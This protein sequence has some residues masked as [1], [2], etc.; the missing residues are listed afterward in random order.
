MKLY[1]AGS[2]RGGR[3]EAA[4]Y[5]KIIAELRRYG[6]V[7]T[8]HIGDRN[9]TDRGENTDEAAIYNRDMAWLKESDA[10][11]AEVTVPS[12]GVG[13]EICAAEEMRKPVLCLFR[14]DGARALSAMLAG[15]KNIT[16]R[17]YRHFEEVP[18]ILKEHFQTLRP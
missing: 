8:E 10:L 2:I 15:N 18:A 17:R 9:L 11:V 14:E 4:L 1:F 3:E 6:E 5:Q 12:L 7:L 16:I 13:Y